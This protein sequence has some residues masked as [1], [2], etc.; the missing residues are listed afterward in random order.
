AQ[1]VERAAE[2][3]LLGEHADGARSPG[4][5]GDGEARGVA[6]V[7]EEPTRGARALHLG[8]DLDAIRGRERGEG[9]TRGGSGEGIRFDLGEAADGAP[10]GSVGESPGDEI[11][12]HST[13]APSPRTWGP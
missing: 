4:L 5:V 9:V 6:D 11:G 1:V 3:A 10:L 13:R 7:G 8:D 12:E 2:A